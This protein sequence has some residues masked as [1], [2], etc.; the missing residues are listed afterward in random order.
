M[1]CEGNWQQR[2][3][4]LKKNPNWLTKLPLKKA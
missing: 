2:D 1:P 3:D 4:F